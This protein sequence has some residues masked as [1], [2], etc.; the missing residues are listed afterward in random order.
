MENWLHE[1]I[2]TRMT[3]QSSDD[4][5]KR[6][7]IRE[8][9]YRESAWL[10]L[11]N[12]AV[13]VQTFDGIDVKWSFPSEMEGT[14]PVPEN[15]AAEEGAPMTAVDFSMTLQQGEVKYSMSD[16]AK[17]R[18]LGNYQVEFSRR[19]ASE[20]LA[21][22][23]NKNIID[24]IINGFAAVNTTTATAAWDTYPASASAAGMSHDIAA[25]MGQ[26][27]ANSEMQMNEM[28]KF[29]M[30]VPATVWGMLQ[31]PAT[32]EGRSQS[33]SQYFQERHKL[34]II[35][36]RYS[37]LTATKDAFIYV[38][39]PNTLIHGVLRPGTGGVP[40][41]EEKRV[42]GRGTQYLIRQFFNTKAVPYSASD[43]TSKRIGTI[44]GVLT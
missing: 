12:D 14:Y 28:D 31:S 1:Y 41:V 20:K 30:L 2:K 44:T 25:A 40:L 3:S 33:V 24:A 36:L 26:I 10:S 22:L 11:A 27:L 13:P 6:D 21:E 5:I 8:V 42:E 17:L 38:N 43:A 4:V 15:A 9:I 34:R 18:Q 7:V 19:R 39:S 35:P 32:I 23:K 37:T 29:V 16:Y